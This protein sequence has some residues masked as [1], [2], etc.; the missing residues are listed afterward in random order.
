MFDSLTT[1][2]VGVLF[3]F[4]F[5]GGGGTTFVFSAQPPFPHGPDGTADG[6]DESINRY[7]TMHRKMH[8]TTATIK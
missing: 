6:L 4:G 3:T 2:S 8:I 5:G 7:I 1:G